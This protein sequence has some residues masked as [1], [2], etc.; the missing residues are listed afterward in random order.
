MLPGGVLFALCVHQLKKQVADLH[1]VARLDM[2]GGDAAAVGIHLH[3]GIAG[4]LAAA[5][6]AV[7]R[8]VLSRKQRTVSS[9]SKRR[10]RISTV[11]FLPDDAGH[12]AVPLSLLSLRYRVSPA[13]M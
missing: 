3:V 1:R 5:D 13:W 11:Y 12:N 8:R 10:E 9:T 7:G 2:H 6:L 4:H